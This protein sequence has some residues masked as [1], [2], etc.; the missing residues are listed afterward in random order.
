MFAKVREKIP[1]KIL[2]VGDGPE[3]NNLE[4]LCRELNLCGSVIFVGKVNDTA[5]VLE[6]SDLFILPSETA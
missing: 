3:R 5:H 4:R 2:F 1:S 6:I